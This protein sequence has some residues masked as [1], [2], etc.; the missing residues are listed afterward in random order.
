MRSVTTLLAE[1]NRLQEHIGQLLDADERPVDQLNEATAE[2][3]QVEA[4]LQAHSVA[5]GGEDDPDPATGDPNEERQFAALLRGEQVATHA[6]Q[7]G[8]AGSVIPRSVDERVFGAIDAASPL[9]N[10]CSSI[11]V[12][13]SAGLRSLP[14][15]KQDASVAKKNAGAAQ[16]VGDMALS[17]GGPMQPQ[18]YSGYETVDFGLLQISDQELTQIVIDRL[19]AQLAIQIERD[20]V[21]ALAGASDAA[22]RRQTVG[23]KG[24]LA[25]SDL[26]GTA[27][28]LPWAAR[29]RMPSW[30]IGD[31]VAL[32]LAG[33]T[34]GNTDDRTVVGDWSNSLPSSLVKDTW[35]VINSGEVSGALDAAQ[36]VAYFCP[37]A[38]SIA[39][40]RYGE[41]MITVDATTRAEFGET[42]VIMNAY[43]AIERP[44]DAWCVALRG[45]A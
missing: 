37:L 31:S 35:P 3:R 42:R 11:T 14:V 27:F 15:I 33:A 29:N 20:V 38:Q 44:A 45:K 22:A 19:S 24:E 17:N 8:N 1:Q 34:V 18:R 26:V 13:A 9:V 21:A 12:P 36:D 25:L 2:L 30:V 5:F 41:A 7:I 6:I 39:L 43:V 28:K 32:S 40:V 16:A 10:A 4:E 23:T